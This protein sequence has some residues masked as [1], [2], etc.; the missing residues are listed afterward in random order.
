MTHQHQYYYK[1]V[2]QQEGPGMTEET[3]EGGLDEGVGANMVIEVKTS[4]KAEHSTAQLTSDPTTTQ[5]NSD[6][7]QPT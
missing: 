2:I 3:D 6:F 7:F 1:A 5:S 4:Q